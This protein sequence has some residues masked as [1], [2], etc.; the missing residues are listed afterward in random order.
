MPALVDTLPGLYRELLPALF[1]RAAPEET[2]ATCADCAMCQTSAVSAVDAVDGVSRLFRPD[3][4][5]CTYHPRLPNFLLGALLADGRPGLAEGQ[6]RVR[7]RLAARVGVGPQWLSAP[8]KYS[9]L[10]ASG[11]QVFGRAATLRCPYFAQDTG[12]CTIWAYREAVCSTWFCKYEA[13]ADG[14]R[15]WMSLKGYLALTE[16]Q[17]SRWALLQIYPDYVLEGRDRPAPAGTPLTV[18][19]LDEQPLP[20]A[21]YAAQWGPWAGR[22]QALY[23]ACAEVVQGLKPADLERILG[24]DGEVERHNVERL[25]DAAVSDTLPTTLRFNPAAT[26]KWLPDGSVAMGAYS[27]LDAVA[28]PG[29]AYELLTAFTGREPVEAVRARLRSERQADLD[30]GVLLQLYR[31]RILVDPSRPDA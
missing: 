21:A 24:L 25:L 14:R 19:D 2:K 3:T 26:V 23:R 7:E 27:D 31:H 20:A 8:A 10:Y 9:L 17:L 29:V 4:K 11:R 18:E 15:F 12:A 5:C 22:E 28:L 6:R 1:Q 30:P 16:I 13:G